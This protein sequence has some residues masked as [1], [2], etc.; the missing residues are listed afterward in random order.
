MTAGDATADGVVDRPLGPASRI[1]LPVPPSERCTALLACW[2]PHRKRNWSSDEQEDEEREADDRAGEAEAHCVHL[3][4]RGV[5][6][7]TVRA[8]VAAATSGAKATGVAMGGKAS[9]SATIATLYQ[10]A[11]H[12]AVKA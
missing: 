6:G 1:V 5:A 10:A 2:S 11:S 3:T 12:A 9:T 7:H 4:S 8:T